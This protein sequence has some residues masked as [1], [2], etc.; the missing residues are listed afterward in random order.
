MSQLPIIPSVW[1]I[2]GP[3]LLLGALVLLLPIVGAYR[4]TSRTKSSIWAG[5]TPVFVRFCRQ[6]T[7]VQELH[8]VLLA[9]ED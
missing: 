1:I 2:L 5:A 3:I 9:G 7:R 4:A 6:R 8:A